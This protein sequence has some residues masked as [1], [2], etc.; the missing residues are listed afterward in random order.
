MELHEITDAAQERAAAAAP[1]QKS[2]RVEWPTLFG[3]VEC[4]GGNADA[5]VTAQPST[6]V[7][8]VEHRPRNG[9]RVKRCPVSTVLALGF[10]PPA[11]PRESKKGGGKK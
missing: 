3:P 5:Y 2:E 10:R 4:P 11:K 7:E 9:G 6:G 1:A 8:H